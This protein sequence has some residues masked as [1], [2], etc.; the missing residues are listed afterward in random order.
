MLKNHPKGLLVAFLLKH[1]RKVWI[2]YNDGNTGTFF[3]RPNS[4]CL[5]KKPAKFTAGSIS[6]F[7]PCPAGR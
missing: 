6:V 5:Q 2:L 4:D 3:Y 1:G 7:M